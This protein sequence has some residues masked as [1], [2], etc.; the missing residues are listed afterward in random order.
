MF[1]TIAGFLTTLAFVPQV[2][3]VVKTKHTKSL[4]LEMY[5]MQVIGV[6][7]WLSH[8][9]AINDLALIIANS[10]TFCL[11]LIILTYKVIYK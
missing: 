3:K 9:I 8:G 2:A 10:V 4:S 5:L 1:G 11:S 7:L 6:A